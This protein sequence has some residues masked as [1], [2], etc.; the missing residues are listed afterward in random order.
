MPRFTAQH[1]GGDK[2][3]YDAIN[4]GNPVDGDRVAWDQMME[5]AALGLESAEVYQEMQSW[6][7]IDN[8]IDYMLLSLYLGNVDWP[9]AIGMLVGIGR[10]TASSAFSI[11]MRS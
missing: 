8:F 5:L 3:D 11:G 6:L 1:L 2:D 7:D 10:R 4:A 9:I